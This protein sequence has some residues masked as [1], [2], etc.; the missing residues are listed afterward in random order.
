M[1]PLI[2][3]DGEAEGEN[4]GEEKKPEALEDA[5]MQPAAAAREEAEDLSSS[6]TSMA[7]IRLESDREQKRSLKSAEFFDRMAK[8]ETDQQKP[9]ACRAFSGA[10]A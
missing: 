3:P 9:T 8:P 6:S 4:D 2:A 7:R 10:Q 1:P 5:P